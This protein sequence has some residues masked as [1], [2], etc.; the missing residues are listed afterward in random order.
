MGQLTI[1]QPRATQS[2]WHSYF[3]TGPKYN[4]ANFPPPI[5]LLARYMGLG[6]D[7]QSKMGHV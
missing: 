5:G 1:V 6:I 3:V 2:K 7:N 4:I